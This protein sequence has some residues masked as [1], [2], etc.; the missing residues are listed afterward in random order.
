[1]QLQVRLHAQITGGTEEMPTQATKSI[2][3]QVSALRKVAEGKKKILLV[4]DDIWSREHAE[5][6]DCIDDNGSKLMVTTR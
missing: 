3:D 6:F 1:M 4:L 5:P 2:A